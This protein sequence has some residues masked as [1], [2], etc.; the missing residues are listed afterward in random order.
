MQ[1]GHAVGDKPEAPREHALQLPADLPQHDGTVAR[2]RTGAE[3]NEYGDAPDGRASVRKAV[4]GLSSFCRTVASRHRL[5]RRG[6]F[7]IEEL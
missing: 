3:R 5:R 6:P 7:E 1:A 4:R 2:L